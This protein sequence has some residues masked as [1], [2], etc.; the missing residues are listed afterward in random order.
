MA[1]SSSSLSASTSNEQKSFLLERSVTAL[2]RLSVRLG[3]KEDLASI[4]V[5]S[6]KTILGLKAAS[7]F[8]VT[9]PKNFYQVTELIYSPSLTKYVCLIEKTSHLFIKSKVKLFVMNQHLT[10]AK[11]KAFFRPLTNLTIRLDG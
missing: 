9:L 4:V 11:N 8:Q 3:R 2:L 6:L 5:Q 1:S 10:N 7:V